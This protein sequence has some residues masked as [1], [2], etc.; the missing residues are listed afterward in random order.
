MDTVAQMCVSLINAQK[1]GNPRVVIPYSQFK[2]QIARV[3]REKG[4]VAH[5]DVRDEN[6]KKLVITLAYNGKEGRLHH[7]RRLS[8]PGKR[9]YVSKD[10]I[11]YAADGHGIVVLS[12]SRGVIDDRRARR[13]KLGGE[14]ICEVW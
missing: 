2:E 5:V 3:L 7:I 11:P 8:T 12:T 14:L 9:R 10:D 1:V 4:Y 6:P 13:E